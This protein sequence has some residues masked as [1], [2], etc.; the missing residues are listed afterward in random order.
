MSQYPN[1][2]QIAVA[3]NLSAAVNA[4]APT[5]RVSIGDIM[6]KTTWRIDFAPE[7][8]ARQKTDAQ[9]IVN[10]FD[11]NAPENQPQPPRDLVTEVDTL[12]ALNRALLAKGTI[13]QDDIDAERSR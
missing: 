8:T 2:Q 11:V 12:Q 13:T 6:D 7:A 10:A 9:A 5:V 3:Q 4:V 1:F